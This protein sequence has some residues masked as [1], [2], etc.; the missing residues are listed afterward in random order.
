MPTGRDSLRFLLS[1]AIAGIFSRTVTAPFDRV[2]LLFQ[3][4]YLDTK[5]K[6]RK[7]LQGSIFSGLKTIASEEGVRGFWRGNGLHCL[8]VFPT[9]S[10]R[11][12]VQEML[13]SW[14]L[15]G[16]AAGARLRP[17]Q[18]LAV[19]AVAG[20]VETMFTHPIEVLRTRAVLEYRPDRDANGRKI[21]QS[22]RQVFTSLFREE[23]VG[24]LFSGLLPAVISVA[25]FQAVNFAVYELLSENVGSSAAVRNMCAKHPGVKAF[26]PSLY[27]A[28]SGA[29]AMT[30]MYPLDVV[31]K[32]MMVTKRLKKSK[33]G[34]SAVDV[35]KQI[36]REDGVKGFYR[37]LGAGYYKVV[38]TV[39]TNWFAYE[40]CKRY[41][42]KWI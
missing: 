33:K 34:S 13:K 18:K 9:S 12:F 40:L 30:A 36:Y 35:A 27:G 6:T 26:L 14:L 39:S 29:V 5:T 25:P 1:G 37:G 38:P 7:R 15:Q 41:L 23:G 11:Y 21:T 2:Q 20:A 19:G 32:T 22:Y 8:K 4:G 28:V 10:I 42:H 17:V 16:G 24:S 3:V 31:K